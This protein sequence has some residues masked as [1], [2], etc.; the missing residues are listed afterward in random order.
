M[1]R[2]IAAA[3]LFSAAVAVPASAVSYDAFASFNGVNG[4]GNFNY[5][6][7]N[8]STLTSFDFSGVNGACALGAGSTC[9]YAAALGAIP[10]ASI[11]GSFSTVNVPANAVL[12]HPGNSGALSV[13]AAFVATNAGSY[14][15]DIDLQSVGI[16]T[17]NGTG[18]TPFTA[19][20]G[21]VTLGTRSLLPT[22]LSTGSLTGTATLALGQAFGVIVDF[23]GSF[24]G[25]STGLNFAVSNVPEPASWAMMIAGFGL[26]GAAMRR[27]RVA[28]A[29]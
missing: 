20:G 19:I 11:G 15:Y 27:R 28:L 8:G 9:L 17:S 3:A 1:K 12:V 13:Y 4:N 2:F 23:N 16:D 5:G 6:F 26:T 10:Q 14:S 18:Y 21:V 24:S 25:D 7:T 22:Y 29:A